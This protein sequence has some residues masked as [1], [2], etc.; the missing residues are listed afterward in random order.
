MG[1]RATLLHFLNASSEVKETQALTKR[2]K[3]NPQ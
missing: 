1:N 2:Q 3:E